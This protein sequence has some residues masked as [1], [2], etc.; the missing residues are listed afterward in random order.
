MVGCPPK[1]TP[2]SRSVTEDRE[3]KLPETIDPKG[4]VG[5]VAMIEAGNGKNADKIKKHSDKYCH[6]TPTHPNHAK[7]PQ[8]QDQERQNPEPV[9]FSAM[10]LSQ[11]LN[12]CFRIKPSDDGGKHVRI[13][14]FT[15]SGNPFLDRVHA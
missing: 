8:M 7:A 6:R 10:I 11:R 5:K 1:G 14:V 15:T 2:L 9:R 12:T 3:K 13:F 4:L